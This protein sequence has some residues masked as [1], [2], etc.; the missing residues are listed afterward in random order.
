MS[1]QMEHFYKQTLAFLQC[2]LIGKESFGGTAS[3]TQPNS[4]EAHVNRSMEGGAVCV[5]VCDQIPVPHNIVGGVLLYQ[6]AKSCL[7]KYL[8]IH[9]LICIVFMYMRER[10]RE[11]NKGRKT[12]RQRSKE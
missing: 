2:L 6:E 12:G 11:R 8:C 4:R 3:S 5:C 10:E 9:P 7:K 1:S